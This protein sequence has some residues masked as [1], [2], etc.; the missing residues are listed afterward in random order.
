MIKKILKTSLLVRDSRTMPRESRT[1]GDQSTPKAT[2]RSET[3]VSG[4]SARHLKRSEAFEIFK[5]D[6][7]GHL[8]AT[9]ICESH[10]LLVKYLWQ[11]TMGE[12]F[13]LPPNYCGMQ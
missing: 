2:R 10:R 3:G 9:T 7:F 11:T 4:A 12:M 1:S 8:L 6:S 5:E 13:S